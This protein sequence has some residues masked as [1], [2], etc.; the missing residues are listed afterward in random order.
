MSIPSGGK[1][2]PLLRALLLA[3]VVGLTAVG[4]W[5]SGAVVRRLLDDILGSTT[6]AL[7]SLVVALIVAIGLPAWVDFIITTHSRRLGDSGGHNLKETLPLWNGLMIAIL[8][9]AFPVFTRG[10]LE[11]HGGWMWFGGTDSFVARAASRIGRAIP[12]SE[13]ALP[14]PNA[15][16][17]A[18]TPS[19]SAV[20]RLPPAAS[21]TS[22]PTP[23]PPAALTAFR[24]DQSSEEI[25]RTRAPSVV[26][27]EIRQRIEPD[28]PHSKVLD[29]LGLDVQTGSGSGFFVG[30]GLIVTNDH[31]MR[32]AESASVTT[33][34]EKRFNEVTMLGGSR[35]HDLALI[36]V[37]GARAPALPLLAS[38]GDVRVGSG[39]IAI[40]SPLGLDFSLTEGI[41]SAK[42]K[43][44]GTD[45]F[46]MQTPIGP[47]S[48]GGPLLNRRGELIGVNTAGMTAGLNLAVHVRHVHALLEAPRT[49]R[50]LVP[51]TAAVRVVEVATI[52]AESSSIERMSYAQIAEI[53]ANSVGRCVKA[54]P[55]NASA[56][57]RSTSATRPGELESNLDGESKACLSERGSLWAPLV[58]ML[59]GKLFQ[60]EIGAGKEVGLRFVLEGVG[61]PSPGSDA[62]SEG[63]LT[64]SF[65]IAK[66][67]PESPPG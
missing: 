34:D 62:G 26:L 33:Y 23:P 40:G 61:T 65:L 53:L 50:P 25:F 54:L 42:R 43:L 46:Q 52:G 10:A 44:E 1:P 9:L 8:V 37:K 60:R 58:G 48:S 64:M 14:L 41:V 31:V 20:P 38:D 28:N 51:F 24:T 12:R 55:A 3:L 63:R 67:R 59:M 49:P 36:A 13:T 18:G 21:A 32:D 4:V 11:R 5:L 6:L 2:G 22:A 17:I 29:R 56:T 39:A 7:F 35:D 19:A 30:D 16:E 45:F 57:F 15:S 27:I 66:P 47:G